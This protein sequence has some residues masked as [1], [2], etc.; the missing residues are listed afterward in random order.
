MSEEIL[1]ILKK[2]EYELTVV[3]GLYAAD[4]LEFNEY[5]QLDTSKVLSEIEEVIKK[6]ENQI[7]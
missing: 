6:L 3:N 5:F 7:N 4:N 2:A 1:K